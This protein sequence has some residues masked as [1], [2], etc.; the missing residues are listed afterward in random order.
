VVSETSEDSGLSVKSLRFSLCPEL[1]PLC[2]KN[3]SRT[4]SSDG[5]MYRIATD[6][7]EVDQDTNPILA[8]V[9]RG[10]VADIQFVENVREAGAHGN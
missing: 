1:C 8:Y 4:R 6:V 7:L 3:A 9:E 2:G 5:W 10:H